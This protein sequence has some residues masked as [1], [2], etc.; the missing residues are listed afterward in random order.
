MARSMSFLPVVLLALG[1]WMLSSLMPSQSGFVNS[2]TPR[3]GSKM[4]MRG[5]KD[6]FY[7]WKD[8]LSKDDQEMLSELA[9][10][11]AVIEGEFKHNWGTAE[12]LYKSEA[13]DSFGSKYLLGIFEKEED[14]KK[15]FDVWNKE[16]EQA[17]FP[18]IQR[19]LRTGGSILMKPIGGR[20]R[21]ERE[22]EELGQGPRG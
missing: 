21:C 9:K 6:D 2:A 13:I 11:P 7:A 16:Y 22:P 18:G 15:A 3:A 10:V 17:K 20:Q 8:T 4:A 12:T 1:A 19:S 5:F 14:A